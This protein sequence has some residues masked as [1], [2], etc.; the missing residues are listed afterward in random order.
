M[1]IVRE[2]QDA[3]PGLGCSLADREAAAIEAL[4]H[5]EPAALA[6]HPAGYYLADS[7]GKDSCVILHLAQRAGVAFE[8]HH[9]LTTIDPPELVR[10]GRRAH[11][12]TIVDVPP[13][14]LLKMLAEDKSNGPPTRIARW[15]CETYKEGHGAD[16]IKVAGI[17]AAESPR[18]AALWGVFTRSRH[19]SGAMLCPIVDWSTADVWE[20]LRLHSVPHSP[21][22]DEGWTRLG[23]VGCPMAGPRTQAREFSR[24]PKMERAWQAAFRAFWA[25]WHNVPRQRGGPRWFDAAGMQSWE[26]LW[27]WWTSG[28]AA[29]RED[30][31]CDEAGCQ[32]PLW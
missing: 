31:D 10:W 1:A 25:R 8:A 27:A 18:R 6:L 30:G 23:C 21:L 19:D 28:K 24:W 15:C 9:H 32:M 14:P 20:Y 5:Y 16:R 12:E 13:R 2:Y 26:D 7:Y 3:I 17:R 11:P 22:Y 29:E 4:R